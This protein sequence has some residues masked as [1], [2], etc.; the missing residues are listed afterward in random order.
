[1]LNVFAPSLDSMLGLDQLEW[2]QRLQGLPKRAM[3]N[4]SNFREVEPSRVG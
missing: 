2:H 1:M 4:N 3:W